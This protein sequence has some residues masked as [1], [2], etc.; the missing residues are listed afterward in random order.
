MGAE[1]SA[2]TSEKP[3]NGENRSVKLEEP[4]KRLRTAQNAY[5]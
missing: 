1:R 2:M 5:A 4:S 3:S